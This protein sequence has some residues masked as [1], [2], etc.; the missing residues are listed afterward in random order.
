MFVRLPILAQLV[1]DG[2][3]DEIIEVLDHSNPTRNPSDTIDFHGQTLLHI[4]Q[5]SRSQ[6]SLSIL[7]CS[8][9]KTM[10]ATP[11]T[12]EERP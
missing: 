4:L 2:L 11:S 10:A 3:M 1:M 9:S 5:K 7:I 8:L 12:H 6:S